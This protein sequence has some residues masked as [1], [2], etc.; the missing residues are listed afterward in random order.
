MEKVE[1]PYCEEYV[2]IDTCEHYEGTEEYEC[3][4]CS[5]NFEVN[6]EPTINYLVIGKADCLNGTEHNWVQTIGFPE[7]YFKG[8]YHCADCSATVTF[9]KELAT[10]E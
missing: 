2:K 7:I 6:A 3:P 9:K 4:N 1:Y 8:K 5:K 10:K